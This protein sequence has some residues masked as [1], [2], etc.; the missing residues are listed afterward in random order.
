[1]KLANYSAITGMVLVLVVIFGFI[2]FYGFNEVLFQAASPSELRSRQY[3]D[4]KYFFSSLFQCHGQRYLSEEILRDNINRC[5]HLIKG[6]VVGY[7]VK[8]DAFNDCDDSVSWNDGLKSDN[9]V[10]YRVSIEHIDG[11]RCIGQLI[12]YVD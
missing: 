11:K 9:N 10:V 4:A 2:A 5:E 7:E 3:S 8:Q 12:I 1:M 6:H